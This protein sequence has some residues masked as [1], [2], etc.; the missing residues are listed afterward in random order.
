[1][2]ITEERPRSVQ[3]LMAEV[4]AEQAEFVALAEELTPE[5]WRSPSLCAGLSVRDVLVHIARHVHHDPSVTRI[6]RAAVQA[7]FS[8]EGASALLDAEQEERFGA[9]PER[10][11]VGLLAQPITLGNRLVGRLPRIRLTEAVLRHDALLQLSEMVIHQQDVRRPLGLSRSIPAGRLRAVLDFTMRRAGGILVNQADS[12]ARGLRLVA[13]DVGW[14]LGDG[15]EVRGPGEGLL[16]AAN[17]RPAGLDGLT[18]D[19]AEEFNRRVTDW[20]ARFRP[21]P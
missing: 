12:K 3:D 10:S 14:V 2:T 9:W 4:R 8:F 19:G 1:M 6:V 18:G 17:G 7:R 20:D 21:G 11:I 5:Q 16:L 13:S 15:P